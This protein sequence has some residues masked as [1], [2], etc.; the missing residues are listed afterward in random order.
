MEVPFDQFVAVELR[1]G[2]VRAA[3]PVEGSEKLL[4]LEVDLG[5][6]R[7]RQ[8]LSGI[9]K[10]VPFESLVGNQYL[11]AAN[12]PPRPMMGLQSEAMLLATDGEDEGL[13]LVRPA[14]PVAPGA[15]LR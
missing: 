9:A 4:R 11:F 8:V 6:E 7:P 12:L 13:V 1:V 14:S 15:R 5:E 2:T 3:S 10:L